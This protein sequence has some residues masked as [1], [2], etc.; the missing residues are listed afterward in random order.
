MTEFLTVAKDMPR[1]ATLIFSLHYCTPKSISLSW[2]SLK[3]INKQVIKI[4]CSFSSFLTKV[5]LSI[6]CLFQNI[7]VSSSVFES[8]II[9]PKRPKYPLLFSCCS[10]FHFAGSKITLSAGGFPQHPLKSWCSWGIFYTIV[11]VT[12]T[13]EESTEASVSRASSIIQ[14]YKRKNLGHTEGIVIVKEH[15]WS[16]R[17]LLKNYYLYFMVPLVLFCFVFLLFFCEFV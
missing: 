6:L 8:D 5:S 16:W 11:S 12:V 14:S 15:W 10:V 1:L 17:F 9:I 4:S 2:F 7:T 13:T 3:Q